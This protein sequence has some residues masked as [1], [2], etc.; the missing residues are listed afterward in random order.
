MNNY[1][2]LSRLPKLDKNQIRFPDF[3]TTK[4]PLPNGAAWCLLCVKPF[5]MPPFKAIP[6]QLCEECKKVYSDTARVACLKC[7][8]VIFRIKP[9]VI[10]SG[11]YIRPRSLLHVNE[12]NV[13]HPGLAVSTI[14]EIDE[15]ERIAR[16]KKVIL[17]TNKY[18]KPTTKRN[19]GE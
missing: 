4:M 14:V 5:T 8:V 12:C 13:C 7:R 6:D 15:W 18:V 3:D 2:L 17:V 1:E 11:Y 10:D 16:P 19:I 9:G